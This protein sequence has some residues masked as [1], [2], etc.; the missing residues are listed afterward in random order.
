MAAASPSP[1]SFIRSYSLSG[2]RTK[3][4]EEEEEVISDWLDVIAWNKEGKERNQ[5]ED[6]NLQS[7]CQGE[8]H[9]RWEIQEVDKG[10]Q[11]EYMEG[12]GDRKCRHAFSPAR[13]AA[14]GW[15][16]LGTGR[17]K[18]SSHTCHVGLSAKSG[19]GGT[20]A[21]VSASSTPKSWKEESYDDEKG[22]AC[23]EGRDL[24]EE[25][26]E[27]EEANE[28]EAEEEA[29]ELTGRFAT[30]FKLENSRRADR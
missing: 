1:V 25:Q 28:E 9:E 21:L 24:E 8:E 13:S 4:E 11:R 26:Q 15:A 17:T 19:A 20:T 3:T 5:G 18:K 29:G 27:E 12:D 23:G 16:H 7:A 22:K 14:E 30:L 10:L 6:T 2:V